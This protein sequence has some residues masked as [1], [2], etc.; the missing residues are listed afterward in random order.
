MLSNSEFAAISGI[1]APLSGDMEEFAMFTIDMGDTMTTIGRT[2]DGKRI[3]R[4]ANPHLQGRG[5]HLWDV[6]PLRNTATPAKMRKATEVERILQKRGA[7][8]EREA[9]IARYAA[10]VDG[11]AADTEEGLFG[12]QEE[13]A[14]LD[15]W[16]KF[17]SEDVEMVGGRCRRRG[18]VRND[19]SFEEFVD[20]AQ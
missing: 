7:K 15:R 13:P 14:P 9:N 2:A 10:L 17:F 19:T 1:E 18:G 6:T 11:G 8:A 20:S 5:K 4:K 3:V 12:I 16:D